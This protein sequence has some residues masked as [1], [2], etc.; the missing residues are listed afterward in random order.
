MFFPLCFNVKFN[1]TKIIGREKK[2]LVVLPEE[3][4]I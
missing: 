3:N 4:E 1:S 2:K